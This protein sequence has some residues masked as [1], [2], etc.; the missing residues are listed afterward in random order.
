M[1]H[2][3][4]RRLLQCFTLAA[5]TCTA[6]QAQDTTLERVA[7]TGTL[8]IGYRESSIPFSYLNGTEPVGFALDLCARIV[9]AV[10]ARTGRSDLKVAMHPV[11]SANRIPLLL[12]RTIDIECGSTTNNTA[13]AQQVAF[14]IN[15]FYTGTRL[16][17]RKGS[18][19]TRIEDLGSRPLVTTAGTTNLQVLRKYLFDRKLE[20]P[21]VSAKDHADALLYVESGRAAAFGMD[22]IL[23][24]GLAATARNPADWEVVGEALQVEPYAVMLRKDDPEFKALVNGTLTQVIRS[25][26]F[27][28]LYRKWF[29]SP[30][31]PRGIN[32]NV[33]MSDEL[34][35]HLKNPSDRPAL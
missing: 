13:R 28:A 10:K 7:A 31:P 25:G 2:A 9:E 1:F 33:P 19:I 6:A 12:N 21:L 18:G 20:T 15:H 8:N 32:L 34:R 3:P 16:L 4:I 26:E 5:L 23:L 22:D 27:E 29:Q 17:T 11:T 14:G 30:I 24:Y 35:E